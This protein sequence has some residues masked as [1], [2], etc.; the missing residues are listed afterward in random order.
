MLAEAAVRHTRH[1]HMPRVLHTLVAVVLH[2]P[3]VQPRLTLLVLEFMHRRWPRRVNPPLAAG[4][5]RRSIA[6]HHSVNHA[7]AGNPAPQHLRQSQ[8]IPQQAR[9]SVRIQQSTSPMLDSPVP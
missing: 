8:F 6:R 2:I 4:N 3:V 1:P 5:L 9:G 7:L